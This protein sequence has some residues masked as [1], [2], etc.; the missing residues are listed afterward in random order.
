MIRCAALAPTRGSMASCAASAVLRLTRPVAAGADTGWESAAM[1][2]LEMVAMRITD[3]TMRWDFRMVCSPFCLLFFRR[4][5]DDA[6]QFL[7]V[8]HTR[9]VDPL[10]Q[11]EIALSVSTT[12]FRRT[13]SA[14]GRPAC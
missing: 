7:A 2:A 9:T 8:S 14:I 11:L 10:H 5:I 12:S 4:L 6:F 13:P 1:A 3:R